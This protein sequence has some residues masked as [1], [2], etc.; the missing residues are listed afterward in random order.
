MKRF[1]T[2]ASAAE[3]GGDWRVLLDGRPVRT[4]GGRPQVV[5]TRALAEALAAEW[6]GQGEE[7][8]AAAF[9]LRDLA[10]Y[11]VDIAGEDR[12]TVIAEALRYAETDTLCYR[13]DPDE[14]LH[15]RQRQVWEPVLGR[16]EARLGIRFERISG[17]IHRPQ[18]ADT[19]AR[20]R[21]MLDSQ[22]AFALTAVR[23]LAGLAASLVVALE[24]LEP[25]ADADALW[26]VADLEEDWQAE[27]WGRDWEAEER[28]TRRLAAFAAAMRFA[29]LARG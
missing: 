25:G 17:I 12:A 14:P 28:R 27:L 24:A 6:A 4:A 10:D 15:R 5:P 18:P 13:A 21:A 3:N 20:L 7:I 11:A 23:T 16:I 26:A 8:D 19:L 29:G 9:M 1:Y 22:D 2:E